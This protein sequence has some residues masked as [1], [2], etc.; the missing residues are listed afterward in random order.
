MGYTG[1]IFSQDFASCGANINHA[2]LVVGYGTDPGT[3]TPYWIV[4]NSWGA[5]WGEGGYI[6]IKRGSNTCGMVNFQPSFPTVSGAPPD[7]NPPPSPPPDPTPPPPAPGCPPTYT[8]ASG[9]TLFGIAGKYGVNY[10]TLLAANPQISTPDLIMI[11]Q[12]VNIPCPAQSNCA[13]TYSV[14][15]GDTLYNIGQSKGISL[16]DMLT[17]NPQF[18]KPDMV[19]PGEYVCAMVNSLVL[20]CVLHCSS[21]SVCA[22]V[23][24]VADG[25]DHDPPQMPQMIA[26]MQCKTLQ[27]VVAAIRAYTC[28]CVH[29]APT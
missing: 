19:Y 26:Q 2:V 6:R 13:A 11:G 10:L 28:S 17:N 14:K 8:V 15:P 22:L 23:G 27:L 20:D 4:K 3:N 21:G 7:P 16:Q 5:G 18:V 9:D 24:A 25:L 1:G 12:V 29:D